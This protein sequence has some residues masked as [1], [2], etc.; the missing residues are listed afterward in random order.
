MSRNLYNSNIQLKDGKWIVKG[1]ENLSS[2]KFG[3]IGFGNIGRDLA[4]IL[5]PLDC[6]IYY[7]DILKLKNISKNIFQNQKNLYTRNVILYQFIYR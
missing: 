2:K 3:I 5:G 4:K 1:G 7:N 6:K